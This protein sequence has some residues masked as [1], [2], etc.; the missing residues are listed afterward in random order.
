L[1]IPGAGNELRLLI[2]NHEVSCD[3]FDPPGSEDVSVSIVITTPVGTEPTPG[4][5]PWL[6]HD[7]HGGEVRSPVKPYAFPTARI[8]GKSYVFQPGG[9]AVLKGLSLGKHGSVTGL[10]NFEFAG[11]AEQP[12]TLLKGRFSARI[13]RYSIGE[14][15]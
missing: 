2:A 9:G 7:A 1:E 10:L 15:S 12:A 14:T 3:A 13:C 6:G 11:D 5:Y 8:G 4:V